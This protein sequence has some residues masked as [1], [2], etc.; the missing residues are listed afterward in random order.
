MFED[1]HRDPVDS[2][3]EVL[4]YRKDGSQLEGTS[5]PVLNRL[6]KGQSKKQQNRLVEEY[7]KILGT[8]VILERPLS[9]T[10]LSKLIDLPERLISL[11]LKLL[12][13]ILNVPED[14][15]LPVRLFHLSF[16]DFLLDPETKERNPFWVDE[17]EVHHNMASRCLLLCQNVKRNI[18]GLPSIGTRREEIDSMDITCCLSPEVQYA[19]R[20]WAHHRVQS[21][22]P[23][24]EMEAA[25]LFLQSHFLHWVEVMSILEIVSEAVGMVELLQSVKHVSSYSDSKSLYNCNYPNLA[26]VPS[27][28]RIRK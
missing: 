4:G 18:C 5:L 21:H 12:H 17:K 7:Q 22:S 19:C 25:F 9:I 2:L 26:D 28:T 14:K 20:Y 1:P 23:G 24:H 3:D 16:R 15:G 13:S 8:I 10:T 27:L 6:L 11:R